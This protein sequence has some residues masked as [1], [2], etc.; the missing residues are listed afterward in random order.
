MPTLVA[1]QRNSVISDL[2]NR[3]VARGKPKKV[4][5][6]ACMRKLLI[7]ANAMVCDRSPWQPELAAAHS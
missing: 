1:I 5:I 6:V 4:A 7:I 2:Y 3:L